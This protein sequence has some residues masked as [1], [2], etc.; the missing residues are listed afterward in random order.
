MTKRTFILEFSLLLAVQTDLAARVAL[1]RAA[2][3]A[4]Q[5]QPLKLLISIEQQSITAPFPARLTLHLHNSGNQTLWLYHRARDP[6]A[7]SPYVTSEEAGKQTSGGASLEVVLQ[8]EAIQGAIAVSAPAGGRLLES[9]GLPHPKLVRLDPGEDYEEKTVIQLQPPTSSSAGET[10]PIWGRYRLAITYRTDYSNRAEIARN[11]RIALWAGEVVSNTIEIELLPP[12][13]TAQG[14]AAGAV[15]GPE[16][17]PILGVLVSLSNQDERLIDQRITDAEGRFSFDHLPLGL[18][19][20]TARLLNS[21]TDT[22][23]FRHVELTAA[24]PA[25]AIEL[26]M[27]PQERSEE[28]RVGKECRSRW[29]P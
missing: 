13:A 6:R 24:E 18:Y 22:A 29:S 9:S 25:G 3:D 11:L 26:V 7:P 10:K 23:V 12:P 27:L 1:V 19:W 17:H 20:L 16:E 5:P 4:T 8:P 15:V 14:S 2:K 28:R 21:P